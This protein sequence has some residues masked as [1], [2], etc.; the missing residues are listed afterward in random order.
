MEIIASVAINVTSHLYCVLK[1]RPS[2]YYSC[3]TQYPHTVVHDILLIVT[4]E[5]VLLS[6]SIGESYYHRLC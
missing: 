4:L 6:T 1:Q 5:A 2:T 3:D